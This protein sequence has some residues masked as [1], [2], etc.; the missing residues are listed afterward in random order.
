MRSELVGNVR[1][2]TIT[3]R[4]FLRFSLAGLFGFL[5][6]PEG[7]RPR[8]FAVRG[9][10]LFGPGE[11]GV[12]PLNESG[13]EREWRLYA[14]ADFGREPLLKYPV[15]PNERRETMMLLEGA[16]Q[17]ERS[18]DYTLLLVEK[19]GGNNRAVDWQGIEVGTE[20]VLQATVKGPNGEVLRR[21]NPRFPKKIQTPVVHFTFF[22]GQGGERAAVNRAVFSFC[23]PETGVANLPLPFL[24]GLQKG[25]GGLGKIGVS[26][27]GYAPSSSFDPIMKPYGQ[28]G[29]DFSWGEV[30]QKEVRLVKAVPKDDEPG[31]ALDFWDTSRAQ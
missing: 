24:L 12:S 26:F 9:N 6:S 14:G 20:T 31:A 16:K 25:G 3:R 30:S 17:P 22:E 5:F 29:S 1:Q 19:I 8:E 15:P 4:D 7:E 2:E 28:E 21:D 11:I 23:D 18:A 27:P 13:K 10:P